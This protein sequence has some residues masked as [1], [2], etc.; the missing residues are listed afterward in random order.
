MP[1]RSPTTSSSS[2]RSTSSSPR[3]G[4]HDHD[5]DCDLRTAAYVLALERLSEAVE[6]TGTRSYFADGES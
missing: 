3:P 6:A 4:A 1:P 5:H 2:S